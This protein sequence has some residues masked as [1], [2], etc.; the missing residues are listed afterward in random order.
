MDLV[1]RWQGF[2]ERGGRFLAI[3]GQ[4]DHLADPVLL[5]C[6]EDR[7]GLGP[8][9]IGD[10]QCTDPGPVQSNQ[11]LGLAGRGEFANGGFG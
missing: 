9:G 8:G 2:R 7:G 6:I 1:D 11:D 3:S 5:E 4:Q 10:T